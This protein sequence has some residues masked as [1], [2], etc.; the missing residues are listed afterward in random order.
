[1]VVVLRVEVEGVERMAA[2]VKARA[3][4]AIVNEIV[5]I[6]LKI[7]YLSRTLSSVERSVRSRTFEVVVLNSV[8]N[9]IVRRR[10]IRG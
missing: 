1:V 6:E 10:A 7:M 3:A 9:V 2:R 8:T 4:V 5:E